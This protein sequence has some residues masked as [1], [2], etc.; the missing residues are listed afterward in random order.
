MTPKINY[1]YAMPYRK[2]GY[3]EWK[4]Y[5]DIVSLVT[6]K[7]NIMPKIDR[8]VNNLRNKPDSR[9]EVIIVNQ[10]INDNSCLLS[11]QFQISDNAL[12]QIANYRSQCEINGRPVD[13]LMNQYLATT[14]SGMLGLKRCKIFV[15]VGNY[16]INDTHKK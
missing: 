11:L 1:H 13:T 9:Q 2:I 15:N 3:F 6:Y 12:I 7:N 8:I 4:R 16:H 14:V 10:E 5:N